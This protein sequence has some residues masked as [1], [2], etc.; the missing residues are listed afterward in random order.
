MEK[1][2]S[3]TYLGEKGSVMWK[4][5]GFQLLFEEDKDLLSQ[6]AIKC[7]VQVSDSEGS[8]ARLPSNT[9]VVSPVFNITS[10]QKLN[11]SATLKI[12]HQAS[13]V[14]IDQLCF[15]TS[16]DNLPPYDYRIVQGGH[17]TSTYGEISVQHFSFHTICH[18]GSHFGVKG[19]LSFMEKRYDASLY[20]SS[21]PMFVKSG[22][23]WNIYLSIV[24]HC[25]I[26]R[27]SVK[28]YI[29]E[30]HQEDVKLVKGQV[31]RF[32]SIDNCITAHHQSDPSSSADF[33]L[34]EPDC[35]SLKCSDIK[36]YV[37]GRPPL[38]EYSLHSKS[39]CSL[40]LKITLEGFED[41]TIFTLRDIHLP[42]ENS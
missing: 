21:R 23:V 2:I 25:D 17:F 26:F 42:G 19:V 12:F 31:V 14:H 33:K 13:D 29:K 34:I 15:L 39:L 18:L 4:E 40:E 1:E 10:S 6:A 8:Y 35:M 11:S 22:Y 20:C 9:E 41:K 28:N 38:L 7:S 5:A 24:K 16:T 3:V 30:E 37:S 36:T 32:N 27:H